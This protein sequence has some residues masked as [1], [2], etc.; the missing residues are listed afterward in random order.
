MNGFFKIR[1]LNSGDLKDSDFISAQK[2]GTLKELVSGLELETQLDCSNRIFDGKAAFLLQQVFNIGPSRFSWTWITQ[3][4]D[5]YS[6]LAFICLLTT[7]SDTDSYT[8]N[9]IDEGGRNIN[10][11]SET[12]NG[13]D[14]NGGAKRFIVDQMYDFSIEAFNTR[15]EVIFKNAWMYLPSQGISS[16]IRSLGIYG[17]SGQTGSMNPSWQAPI[18][19]VG[20]VRLKDENGIPVTITKTEHQVLFIEYQFRLLNV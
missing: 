8:E 10:D 3:G 7:D 17:L 18:E 11:T 19:R 15:E 1:L 5:A 4:V 20:R 12:V 9:L 6:T 13:D 2:N 16:N 14:V